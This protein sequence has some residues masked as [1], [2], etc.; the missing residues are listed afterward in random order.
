MVGGRGTDQFNRVVL[1]VHATV[2][3]KPF[4]F[5]TALENKM[6]PDIT[7]EDNLSN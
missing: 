7:I 6:T 1:A 5:A 3:F 4:T 2:A